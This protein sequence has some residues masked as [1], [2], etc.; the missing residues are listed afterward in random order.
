MSVYARGRWDVQP[1]RVTCRP[2]CVDLDDFNPQRFDRALLRQR[3][4]LPLDALVCVCASQLGGMYYLDET[5]VFFASCRQH[6]GP[7][8]HV[9]LLT[10][11]SPELIEARAQDL[12]LDL[13][14][15]DILRCAPQEVP[16]QLALGDFALNPQQA[17]PSKKY[18]TPVKNG[19]YWAMGL[20]IVMMKNTS[21]DSSLALEH[22]TGIVLSDLSPTSM[23]LNWTELDRLLLDPSCPS[24]CRAL[25]VQT[26]SFTIA[27]RAYQEIY[28][29]SS[30]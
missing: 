30:R 17:V 23:V 28:A 6:F 4:G 19:E 2:A 5:L 12:G 16:E 22:G 11:T 15:V 29:N 3:H 1:S 18:G 8:F 14:H 20:P 13:A 7:R 27:D 24:R 21:Q 9:R 10:T 25:A 26:R